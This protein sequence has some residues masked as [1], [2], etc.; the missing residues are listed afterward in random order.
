MRQLHRNFFI[1]AGLALGVTAANAAGIGPGSMAPALDVKKWYKGTP[2]KGFEKDKVYIVEFWATWCGPC[3]TSIPHVTK[4]AK[5]NPDVTVIGVSIWE[6]DEGTKIQD[7]INKMGDKMDYNV[8]YSGN[9]EGMA[10]TWMDAAGQNG[11]PSA[12]IIKNQQIQ[13]VGHPMSMDKPLAEIKAGTFDLAAFR[14]DFEKRA[15][16]NRQAAAARAEMTAANKLIAD[17][18]YAEAKIKLNEIEAKSPAMKP[19]IQNLRFGMLAKEN[20]ATWEAQA[21]QMAAS[22]DQSKIQVLVGFAIAQTQ[23][24]GDV[25]KGKMAM[26][27]ALDAAEDKDLLTFYNGASF[28]NTLKDYKT[29]LKWAEKAVAVI[30][31]SQFKDNDQAKTAITKLRDDIAAKVKSG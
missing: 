26:N 2:V 18:K 24:G 6:D 12:F 22:K 20:P 30:P 3:I 19:Q 17:G 27:L 21:K 1:V 25:D 4:L 15:E 16:A 7:F 14:V 29:A 8:G 23:K 31:I 9:K 5:E 10:A 28:Y 11:I 13:W